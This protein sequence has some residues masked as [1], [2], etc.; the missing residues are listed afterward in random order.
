LAIDKQS[1]VIDT[2]VDR[3]QQID[4]D[5]CGDEMDSNIFIITA[6]LSSADICESIGADMIQKLKRA[7]TIR[8][9]RP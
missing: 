7:L 1:I 5:L 6:D 3:L 9:R 4:I 2:S 8:A